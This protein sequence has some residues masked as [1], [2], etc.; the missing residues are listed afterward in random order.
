[1]NNITKT[2]S[3]FAKTWIRGTRANAT[4]PKETF[5]KQIIESLCN[6]KQQDISIGLDTVQLNFKKFLQPTNEEINN[7]LSKH[8]ITG[9]SF[10]NGQTKLTQ[11]FINK[12]NSIFLK[13]LDEL[14]PSVD[15]KKTYNIEDIMVC[16][17]NIDHSGFN[18][19]EA[20]LQQFIKELDEIKL[21]TDNEGK[22]LFDQGISSLYS[23]KA[24]IQSKYNNPERYQ[25]IMDLYKLIKQGKAPKYIIQGLIPEGEFHVLGK[26]DIKKLIQGKDYFE[27]FTEKS[28]RK[29]ILE[30]TKF[31]DVFSVGSQMFIRTKDSYEKLNMTKQMYE[32]LFPPIERY[33]MAQTEESCHF[34]ATLDGVIKNHETRV[35]MYKMFE[36]TGENS[37]RV[38][39]LDKRTISTDFNLNDIDYLNVT[40]GEMGYLKGALGLRMIEHSVGTNMSRFSNCKSPLQCINGGNG[41]PE[42][43]EIPFLTGKQYQRISI[44]ASVGKRFVINNS[45]GNILFVP[46]AEST[47]RDF[48]HNR[49]IGFAGGHVYSTQKGKLFN[50]WNT[51]E[52]LPY[53]QKEAPNPYAV[54]TECLE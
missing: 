45:K 14:Y 42:I 46:T 33:C 48:G 12:N 32:K 35:N 52:S 3:A 15:G 5:A 53:P 2:V 21:M 1:M 25:D 22:L 9:N 39:L 54:W 44:G 7:L 13:R 43:Y 31:G 19:K 11:S 23:M 50:P 40:E 17:E 41:R 47:R 49:N 30:N 10:N 8:S 16:L 24:I 26:S 4:N 37:V 34:V 38:R 20:F 27:Q 29:E 18:N 36:Q 51:I 28:N 6:N